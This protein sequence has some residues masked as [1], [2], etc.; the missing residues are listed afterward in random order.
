VNPAELALI[1]EG[2]AGAPAHGAAAPVPWGTILSSVAL[3]VLGAQQFCRSFGLA[4]FMTEY[5]TLLQESR[6]ATLMESGF[7]NGS[8]YASLVLGSTV[9][10]MIS[11]RILV[12]T[13][14]R[15]LSRKGLGLVSTAG[16][17]LLMLGAAFIDSLWLTGVLVALSTLCL[18]LSNSSGYALTI[19]M[20]GKYV[21][22]VFAVVNMVANF[23]YVVFP[24]VVP[25]L[26]AWSDQNWN[27]IILLVAAAFL[28]ASICWLLF[29]PYAR[30]TGEAEAE[31]S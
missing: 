30:I 19:D 15:S 28:A 23:G 9:G 4:I 7:W 27:S 17:A 22:P 6:G 8:V 24:L 1:E 25:L 14:S 3:W 20:G 26:R 31:A 16:G 12:R 21:A 29:N 10:G 13:G 2:P 5:P 11:D 18:S